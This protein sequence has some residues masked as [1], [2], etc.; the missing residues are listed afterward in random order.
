VVIRGLEAMTESCV[1]LF[2]AAT[3]VAADQI[4]TIIPATGRG[5]SEAAPNNR[6][7]LSARGRSA[8]DAWLRTRAAA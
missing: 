1:L 6:L 7:K 5:E 8:A 4:C 3:P 2:R